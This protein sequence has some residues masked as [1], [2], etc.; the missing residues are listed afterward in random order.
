M[1]EALQHIKRHDEQ[2]TISEEF[3]KLSLIPRLS[4]ESRRMVVT[5]RS[6]G[7]SVNE[8]QERLTEEEIHISRRAIHLLVKKIYRE[9]VLLY[10]DT[11]RPAPEK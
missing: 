10:T 6:L 11:R 8:I 7:Y 2:S 5:L 1:L 9:K 3:S 4:I